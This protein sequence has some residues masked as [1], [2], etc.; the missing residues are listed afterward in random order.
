MAWIPR[1]QLNLNAGQVIG[2][3]TAGEPFFAKYGTTAAI[4]EN[5]VGFSSTFNSL[6]VKFDRRFAGGLTMT[7]AFTWQKAMDFET[8]D[9]CAPYFYADRA[10][11]GLMRARISTGP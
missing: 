10:S 7:T 6:Q 9:V 11:D 1:P 8:G 3:G 4:T 5:F 2:A